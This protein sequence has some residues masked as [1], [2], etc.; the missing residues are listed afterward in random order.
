MY[1]LSVIICRYFFPLYEND[2]FLFALDD[3][4]SHTESTVCTSA[5]NQISK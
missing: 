1:D 3:C 4:S 5:S 2:A